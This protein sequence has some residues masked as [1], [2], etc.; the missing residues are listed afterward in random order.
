MFWFFVQIEI[1]GC[2]ERGEE[3]GRSSQAA[4]EKR[5]GVGSRQQQ[6]LRTVTRDTA[7]EQ[8]VHASF[9]PRLDLFPSFL[10]RGEKGVQP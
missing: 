10:W 1:V 7:T 6:L 2:E 8:P 4:P 3:G 9:G 5:K